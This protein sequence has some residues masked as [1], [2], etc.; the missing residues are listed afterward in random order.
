[1]ATGVS[2]IHCEEVSCF[3]IVNVVHDTECLNRIHAS[4]PVQEA[5]QV[6]GSR[7]VLI[8]TVPKVWCKPCGSSMCVFQL[9]NINFQMRTPDAL[10]GLSSEV[11][12]S[13]NTSS[14]M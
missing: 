9:D 10:F 8:A 3:Q 4:S 12:S 7:T 6:Q 13:R 1:M 2:C 5:G 11:Y 14:S